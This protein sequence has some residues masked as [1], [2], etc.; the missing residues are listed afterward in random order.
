MKIKDIKMIRK[1]E[2]KIVLQ[3]KMSASD[4]GRIAISMIQGKEID[5]SERP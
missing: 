4:A 2:F 1:G 5:I 3:G